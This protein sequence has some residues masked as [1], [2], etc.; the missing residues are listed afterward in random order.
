M[1]GM[2]PAPIV[3]ELN[4]LFAEQKTESEQT[5]EGK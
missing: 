2:D 4:E 5:S 1:H 3:K